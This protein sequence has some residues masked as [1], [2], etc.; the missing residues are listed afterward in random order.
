MPDRHQPAD[1]LPGPVIHFLLA[2]RAY[3]GILRLFLDRR[4]LYFTGFAAHS[5]RLFRFIQISEICVQ[6]TEPES[7][8]KFVRLLAVSAVLSNDYVPCLGMGVCAGG[9]QAQKGVEVITA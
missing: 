6:K 7:Q 1:A 3:S 5:S 8:K 2:A 4:A 9:L